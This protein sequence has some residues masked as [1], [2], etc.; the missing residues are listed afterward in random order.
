M[1]SGIFLFIPGFVHWVRS[2]W[3]DPP[4]TLGSLGQTQADSEGK[5]FCE[6]KCQISVQFFVSRDGQHIQLTLES[7]LRRFL[8]AAASSCSAASCFSLSSSCF[9]NI[10]TGSPFWVAWKTHTYAE[11]PELIICQLSQAFS[12][13]LCALTLQLVFPITHCSLP[14][15][16][17]WVLN[18]ASLLRQNFDKPL[19]LSLTEHHATDGGNQ[20]LVGQVQGDIWWIHCCG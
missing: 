19:S 15:R 18:D 14:Y 7:S 12:N 6:K 2:Q 11:T 10:A 3:L 1:F 13:P 8:A 17:P 5:H 9:F 16:L 20:R 4:K